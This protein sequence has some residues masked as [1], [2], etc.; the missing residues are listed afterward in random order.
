MP[1]IPLPE[2]GQPLDVSYIYEIVSSVNSLN[3]VLATN[4]TAQSSIRDSIDGGIRPTSGV[5]FYAQQ[6]NAKAEKVTAGQTQDVP[7]TF[8]VSFQYPPIITATPIVLDSSPA[9]VDTTVYIKNVTTSACT[10]SL[11][12]GT[13]GQA[14]VDIHIIA[15][16][17]P[18]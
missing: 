2:R 8:G 9:S 3:N 16:G 5:S 17:I 15:I 13:A 1:Q 10:I 6:L 7:V 4:Y 18:A 14:D 12:H 11:R